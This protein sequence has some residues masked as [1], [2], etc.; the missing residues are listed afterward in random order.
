MNHEIKESFDAISDLIEVLD[1]HAPD[2]KLTLEALK[3]E[4]SLL[5]SKIAK[6]IKEAKNANTN[7][8]RRIET[9]RAVVARKKL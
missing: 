2:Q 1:T 9:R 4:V 6:A 7:D 3:D 8:K 5:N